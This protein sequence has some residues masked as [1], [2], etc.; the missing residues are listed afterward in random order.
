MNRRIVRIVLLLALLFLGTGGLLFV[1]MPYE[2]L[3]L[4]R[5]TKVADTYDWDFRWTTYHWITEREVLFFRWNES[6]DPDLDG[7]HFFK[8]DLVSGKD[9]YLAAL[10]RIAQKSYDGKH[11]YIRISPDGKRLCWVGGEQDLIHGA[12]F[13]GKQ[14]FTF[15]R[16]RFSDVAWMGDSRHLTEYSMNHNMDHIAYGTIYDVQARKPIRRLTV[17]ADT[18]PGTVA[19]NNH[20]LSTVWKDKGKADD[21][22]DRLEIFESEVG[23][24][25]Q[26]VRKYPIRLP[27]KAE[28]GGE[29]FSPQGDRI[30]WPLVQP[31]SL[32][33][34]YAW[35]H[36]H[37]HA[38]N[39]PRAPKISFW[40]SRIDG[41]HMHEIGYVPLRLAEFSFAELNDIPDHVYWLPDGK[42]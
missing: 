37:I 9:T 10:S 32:P 15:E 29:Q 14:P 17:S 39:P 27:F 24:E 3:L 6:E 13:E 18:T 38:F 16:G 41:S 5:A 20:L 36:R 35:L 4:K 21:V 40:V 23:K 22:T 7:Y 2:P 34:I 8:H 1:Y 25:T 28:I 33:P 42:R 12:T 19:A 30:L 31:D 11:T 26:P